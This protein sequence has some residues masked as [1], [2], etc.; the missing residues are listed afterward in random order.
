M[1]KSPFP[2]LLY[3]YLP[4][5]D[6]PAGRGWRIYSGNTETNTWLK[7]PPKPSA[8]AKAKFLHLTA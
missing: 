6:L 7:L 5:A 3:L 8:R 1:A 2:G 4:V